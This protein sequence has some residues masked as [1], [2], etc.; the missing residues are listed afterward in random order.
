MA[1]SPTGSCSPGT[2]PSADVALLTDSRY[3]AAVAP[4]GDWYLGNILADDALL[5]EA[6]AARGL[7]ALRVDWAR[8]DVDWSRFRTAVFRTTWDYFDRAARFAHWLDDMAGQT[9]LCNAAATVRWNMDKHYL[10]DL[11]RDGIP[12]VP[13]RFIP[14]GS[15]TVLADLVRE[16]GWGE[17][18]IKPCIS[19]GARH[20]HRLDPGTAAAV[21]TG[22]EPVMAAEDFML[23]PF[24]PAIL[25]TGEDSLMVIGG[26]FTHA[27]R[28]RARPGDYRVQDDHGGTV[29]ERVPDA[30]QIELAERALATCS[31]RPAY[32]RVDM[33]VG[34]DGR[35][36]V[37][38]L[39]L[40]E[41]ELWLR[42][43]PPAATALAAAIA[44]LL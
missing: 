32:G 7:S 36:L 14:A 20:T 30:A 18:V 9:R 37:M 29:H 24:Q 10:A 35:W 40:I 42:C 38:E 27:V 6:L 31:P 39:E 3:T 22:L 2:P 19:G 13:T 11:D 21:A 25:T 16:S 33:V 41:P 8:P 1:A 12:V 44:A 43:H 26:R 15:G 34:A 17:A 5:Q 23:Q 28:K 4:P